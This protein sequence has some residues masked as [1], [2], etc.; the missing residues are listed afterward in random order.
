MNTYTVA[1]AKRDFLALLQKVNK[2]HKP[3]MIESN[4]NENDAILISKTDWDALQETLYLEANGVGAVVR[5]REKDNSGF[6]D[7]VKSNWDKL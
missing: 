7:I 6:T 5:R 1:E 3:V 4:N 2:T